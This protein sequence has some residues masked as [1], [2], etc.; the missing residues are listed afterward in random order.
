MQEAHDGVGTARAST[1]TY[2]D[3]T[4]LFS[5]GSGSHEPVRHDDDDSRHQFVAI[6]LIDAFAEHDATG[7]AELDA[8]G[9]AEQLRARETLFNYIDRIWDDAKVRGLEPANRPEWSVVAG[10]RDLTTA[11]VAQAEQAQSDAGDE[12]VV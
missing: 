6:E 8:V 5:R 7:L 1:D 10:L 4:G 3:G 12:G 9:R 2:G 11:L